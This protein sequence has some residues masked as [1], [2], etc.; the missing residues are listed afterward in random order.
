MVR[1][2]VPV[3]T[4]SADDWVCVSVLLVVWVRRPAAGTAGSWVMLSLI[5]RW[6]PS[7]EFSLI[8]PL[9]LGALWQCRVSDSVLLL[10]PVEYFG[11]KTQQLFSLIRKIGQGDI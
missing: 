7:W 2:R 8:N 5:H 10:V 9:G 1:F 3:G 11:S 6:R 4:L